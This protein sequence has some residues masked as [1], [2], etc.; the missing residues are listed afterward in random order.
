MAVKKV[1]A[2]RKGRKT[3][4]FHTWKDCQRAI[5]GFSGAEYKGFED[6]DDALAFLDATK[7]KKKVKSIEELD[8]DEM[9]AYVDGSYDKNNKWYSYGAITFY[10]GER[11]DFSEKSNDK[12]LVD[13]RNVAGELDGA[14]KAMN[15][16][17]EVGAKT[18]YLHYDYEGIEKWANK[19]WKANKE[20]TQDYQKFYQSIASKLEVVFV[21][22]KAHS[23]DKYNEEVDGLAKEVL[24]GKQEK[25]KNKIVKPVVQ[26]GILSSKI[27]GGSITPIFN[28]EISE[29]KY[30][31]TQ[32]IMKKFKLDWKKKRKNI[33]DIEKLNV[34]MKQ[35]GTDI[36][37]VFEVTTKKGDQE[38]E[39]SI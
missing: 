7:N 28:I 6:I 9:T 25:K 3:G 33:K 22:V 1:Y 27:S 37:F 23:G 2:V 15:Y 8:N 21:K 31:N 30:I 5:M 36:K 10:R 12:K 13:M 34:V 16:A 19:S 29:G 17:I 4:I 18:L 32:D 11:K 20:G 38:I 26:D 35:N 39:I 24:F 14:M